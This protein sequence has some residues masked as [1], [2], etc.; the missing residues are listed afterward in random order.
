MATLAE[1]FS[2]YSDYDWSLGGVEWSHY[3]GS[4]EAMWRSSIYPR[5]ARFLPTGTIVE[6]G[7]G[8]GRI[9]EMLHGCARKRL[10][11]TDI[12]KP[13]V[14]ACVNRFRNETNVT[15]L[16][17]DGFSL[18]GID[19][20]S[21]DLIVSIYSLVSSD[22]NVIQAY[23]KEFNRV[24][25]KEGVVF[26]HHSNAGAYF[27]S[28]LID[29]DKS[30]QLLSLYRDITMSAE[31]MRQLSRESGLLCIKQE[32]INWDI[33]EVLSDCF[34]LIVR[35]DSEWSKSPA[36]LNNSKFRSEMKLSKF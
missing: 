24:L 35:S 28:E 10:I 26:L 27:N 11:L 18:D 13:C 7:S 4:T 34:S 14:D 6:I 31:V 17:S 9:S 2:Y 25:K 32:C 15:C 21:V 36:I 19:D 8:H 5:I 12:I 3:W 16:L 1:D 30:M 29:H 33:D 20:N 23:T 22:V